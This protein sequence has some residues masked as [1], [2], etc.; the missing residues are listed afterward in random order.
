MSGSGF[1]Q[2]PAPSQTSRAPPTLYS[3][4]SHPLFDDSQSKSCSWQRIV[5]PTLSAGV[6]ITAVALKV[7]DVQGIG[8][9]LVW[10]TLLSFGAGAALQN[11]IQTGLT[12]SV[13]NQEKSF[14]GDYITA[15]FLITTQVYG[16]TT[17]SPIAK[18]IVLSSLVALGGAASAAM[19]HTLLTRKMNEGQEVDPI[20]DMDA[21]KSYLKSLLFP[22]FPRRTIWAL[23]E[24]LLGSGAI[25]V[26]EKVTHLSL[27]RDFGAFLLGDGVGQLS[28]GLWHQRL[29]KLASKFSS[30]N[31]YDYDSLLDDDPLEARIYQTAAKIFL[32]I[33][34]FLPG[35]LI[36][37][38]GTFGKHK[39]EAAAGVFYGLVGLSTGI[40]RHMERVRFFSSPYSKLAELK[41]I[42]QRDTRWEKGFRIFKWSVAGAVAVYLGLGIAGFDF[43]TSI[44][45]QFSKISAADLATF[46]AFLYGSYALSEVA[47][48][49][50]NKELNKS[51]RN[52]FYF[53]NQYSL[54]PPIVALYLLEKMKIGDIALLKYTILADVLSAVAYASLA[55]GI[56]QEASVR[57]E[58]AHPRIFSAL[59]AALVG[60]FI[61]RKILGEV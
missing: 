44:F 60:E 37:A 18:E 19:V 6:C 8:S 31:D 58:H 43:Q 29:Q 59:S 24:S 46:T 14:I 55:A 41:Y 27:L 51:L 32:P 39:Y 7:L 42:K 22:S 4:S 12:R 53:Y 33:A 49:V 30:F 11:G 57:G 50:F 15:I 13:A 16:N 20:F 26:G 5:F 3:P 47:K 23:F 61:M 48:R 2:V 56:A 9:N 36:V 28:S 35:P 10:G 54:G 21:R 52:E 38:A 17:P 34:H 45:D 1:F 25:V 40:K